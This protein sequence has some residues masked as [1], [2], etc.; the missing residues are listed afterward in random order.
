MKVNRSYSF[1]Y[2]LGI[3]LSIV[4]TI[5][6]ELYGQMTIAS[7]SFITI[8]PGGSLFVDT[9]LKIKSDA[10]GSGY[11]VD[12]TTGNSVTIDGSIS[13]ERYIQANGWHNI[14]IPVTSANTSLFSSTELVF[15][16]DETKIMNDWNFGWVWYQGSLSP[17]KGYDAYLDASDINVDYTATNSTFLNTGTFTVPITLT[18]VTDG[19]IEEH[20]GWNLIGNPYASPVDWLEEGGWDKSYINDAKYIWN[21]DADNYTIFLG[22]SAPLGINGGTQFIPSNQ[23]FWVQAITNG[24]L[25]INNSSRKGIATATPDYYKNGDYS[26]PIISL[27]TYSN[28]LEDETVIRF[29][30]ESSNEFDINYDALK[31]NSASMVLPQISTSINELDMAINSL[32]ILTDGIEIPLNFYCGTNGHYCIEL[33]ETSNLNVNDKIYLFDKIDKETVDLSL[34]E[35]YCFNHITNNL[36]KRFTIIINP[37]QGQLTSIKLESP[38][39][40]FSH[41]NTINITKLINEDANATVQVLNIMGQIICT[42]PL[43]QTTEKLIINAKPSYYIV[44][45]ITR[46]SQYN[47]KVFIQ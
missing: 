5:Y 21:P 27:S 8:N 20:K 32:P 12:Q 2:Y 28:S 44:R 39:L 11:L 25:S 42:K 41:Q 14:S 1:N 37:T 33:N 13:I 17:M 47:H 22:G 31:L 38:Y 16:Y 18:N 3:I 15:Y 7:N 23:G 24:N 43:N 6:G 40:V 9:E 29:I 10:S 35:K 36:N 26:Y 46:N 19:E 45:I 4:F 34:E 30:D